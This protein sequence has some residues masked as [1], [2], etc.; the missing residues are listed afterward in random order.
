MPDLLCCS[1]RPTGDQGS[2]YGDTD[3]EAELRF[4]VYEMYS[5]VVS[6]MSGR[7]FH[8]LIAKAFATRLRRGASRSG[9]LPCIC[10]GVSVRSGVL[11]FSSV[12][13][14]CSLR[15]LEFSSEPPLPSHR[16]A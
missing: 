10:I 13:L 8:E 15:V 4:V 9:F 6:D 12:P 16:D 3:T 14:L 5:S 2:V 11:E 1:G 7:D